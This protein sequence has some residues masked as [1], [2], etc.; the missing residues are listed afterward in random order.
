[1]RRIAAVL[2]VLTLLSGIGQPAFADDS[3]DVFFIAMRAPDIELVPRYINISA[4]ESDT[5]NAPISGC[6]GQTYYATP[7]DAT[8]VTAAMANG[9]IVEL[10]SGDTGTSAQ[11][12]S[13]VCIIQSSS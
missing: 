8:V 10:M 11:N 6:D 2:G 12:A 7:D 5:A 13:A 1:M 9:N 3:D 4:D